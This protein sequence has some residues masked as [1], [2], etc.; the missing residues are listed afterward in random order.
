MR[1]AEP[2]TEI[3]AYLQ[4]FGVEPGGPRHVAGRRDQPRQI[5][6]RMRDPVRIAEVAIDG[7]VS[8]R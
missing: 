7:E 5:S 2:V 3:P 4:R 6:Q 8:S 1:D